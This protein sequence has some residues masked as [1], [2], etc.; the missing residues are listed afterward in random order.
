MLWISSSSWRLPDSILPRFCSFSNLKR[1]MVVRSELPPPTSVASDQT[2]SQVHPTVDFR[3]V[4]V[5]DLAWIRWVPFDAGDEG[6]LIP[7]NEGGRLEWIDEAEARES[8]RRE[9]EE[10]GAEEAED[11]EEGGEDGG[12]LDELPGGEEDGI[13]L[14]HRPR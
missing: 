2:P 12:A 10:E 6:W 14:R 3:Q 11:E 9:V 8:V 4:A 5:H 7:G 1:H 13:G